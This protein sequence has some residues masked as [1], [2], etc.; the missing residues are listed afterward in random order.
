[1]TGVG[2]ILIDIGY[3]CKNPGEADQW[4]LSNI[5]RRSGG[6][7]STTFTNQSGHHNM[8]S[9]HSKW[10][11]SLEVDERVEQ[12]EEQV[13]DDADSEFGGTEA[14][15]KLERKLLWKVGFFCFFFG[16]LVL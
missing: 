9:V 5:Q 12:V 13:E 1:M 11:P 4:F 8:T 16:G 14:R 2:E 3:R 7:V 10:D 15:K 6:L